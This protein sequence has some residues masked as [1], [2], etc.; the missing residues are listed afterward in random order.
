MES[1]DVTRV[2]ALSF[3]ELANAL[4]S[5]RQNHVDQNFVGVS[6]N[7]RLLLKLIHEYKD[8]SVKGNNG[9]RDQRISEMMLIID[10]VKTQI[11]KSQFLGKKRAAELR[12]CNT[13]LRR[14]VPRDKRSNE[15]VMDEK[16]RLRRELNASMAARKSLESICSSIGKEKEIIAKELART[17]QQLNGMEEHLNDLKAQNE[18]LMCKVQAC[19]AEHRVK[20]NNVPDAQANM[21]ALQKRNKVLTEQLLK[22]LDAYRSL[23]RKIKEYQ[24]KRSGENARMEEMGLRVRVGL[25]RIHSFKEMFT[26]NDDEKHID[27]EH[28]ISALEHMFK[29]FDL[30]ISKHVKM[31]KYPVECKHER[32][33]ADKSPV[34]A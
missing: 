12:R 6:T 19:V 14:N 34:P 33:N 17:V 1:L 2:R 26:Q 29:C 8:A 24:E 15:P 11:Q 25:D 10:D 13:D 5:P 23:K 32:I 7:V 9:S 16:E 28:E 3:S 30:E 27:I 18:M 4:T 22:S 21:E 31:K 20:K